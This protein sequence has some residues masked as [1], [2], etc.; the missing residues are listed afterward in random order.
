[1][2]TCQRERLVRF[3]SFRPRNER[4][5]ACKRASLAARSFDLRPQRKPLVCFKTFSLFLWAVVPRL[6]LGMA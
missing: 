3:F 5:R 6:T 2:R 4:E 1:M